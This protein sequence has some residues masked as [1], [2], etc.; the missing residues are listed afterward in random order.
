MEFLLEDRVPLAMLTGLCGFP[1]VGKSWV[2]YKIAA[3]GSNGIDTFSGKKIKPFNTIIWTN[4]ALP[5]TIRRRLKAMGAD[6]D[7]ISILVGAHD[8]DG[9]PVTLT[10][11]NVAQIEEAVKSANASLLLVDPLQ[12]FLGAKTDMNQANQ[13]RPLLDNISGIAERARLAVII[14]RHLAKAGSTHAIGRAL[15]SIDITAKFRTEYL[16]GDAPDGSGTQV[17]AHLKPGE[18]PRQESLRFAIEGTKDSAHL[19]WKGAT[20][21]STQDLL[22]PEKNRTRSPREEAKEYLIEALADGPRLSRELEA[23]TSIPRATLYRAAT[24]LRVVMTGDKR[25]GIGSGRCP[26]GNLARPSDRT[27]I[28]QRSTAGHSEKLRLDFLRV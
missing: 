10:L 26:S 3:D 5:A 15:G 9:R 12:S 1:S 18:L 6:L 2:I 17:I 13:T 4:E 14:V 23:G 16:I 8:S 24:E 7:R 11:E 19:A 27:Q 25:E 28:L 21:I 22:T 20:T